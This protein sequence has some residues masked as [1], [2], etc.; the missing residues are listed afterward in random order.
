MTVTSRIGA[1]RRLVAPAAAAL[2][3]ARVLDGIGLAPGGGAVRADI[4]DDGRALVTRLV[5]DA[6]AGGAESGDGLPLIE[7]A[8]LGAVAVIVALFVLIRVPLVSRLF[9]MLIGRF[10]GGMTAG[11]SQYT[12]LLLDGL[13]VTSLVL[14]FAV[15]L[16]AVRAIMDLTGATP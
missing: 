14:G 13:R 7:T 11:R 10:Q 2:V 12:S 9:T 6:W 15:A 16:L 4:F 8:A 3:A 1:R 5:T